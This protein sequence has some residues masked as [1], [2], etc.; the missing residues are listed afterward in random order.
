MDSIVHGVAESRTPLSAFHFHFTHPPY[1][2]QANSVNPIIVLVSA[3]APATRANFGF[4]C[5]SSGFA[6]PPGRPQQARNSHPGPQLPP[7]EPLLPLRGALQKAS[8]FP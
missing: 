6:D 3:Q 8:H 1:L 2:A 5:P 7:T 4:Q